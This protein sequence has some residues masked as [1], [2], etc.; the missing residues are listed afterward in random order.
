VTRR[1]HAASLAIVAAIAVAC[2]SAGS[3]GSASSAGGAASEP[4]GVLVTRVVDGDTAH[5]DV[6]GRDVTVRFIGI[7]TPEAVAPDQPVECYGREASEYTH[8]RLE[9]RRVRLEFDVERHDRFGRTL[10]Y[11]WLGDELFNETLVREGYA[12]VTTFPPNVRYVDR[13]TAAQRAARRDGAGLW[14]SCG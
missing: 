8:H 12:L 14:G 10:A 1:L 6:E 11:V 2:S 4:V 13:F 9:G 5:V 7:D 3:D